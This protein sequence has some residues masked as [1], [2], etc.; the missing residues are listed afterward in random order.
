MAMSS[1][2]IK[3]LGPD[4]IFLAGNVSGR[5]AKKQVLDS[6]N[7]LTFVKQDNKETS[8]SPVEA[9]KMSLTKANARGVASELSKAE[10][11]K[12]FALKVFG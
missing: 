4:L 9:N 1:S 10:I 5:V 11:G 3:P 12:G 2:P 6:I 8:D 7:N